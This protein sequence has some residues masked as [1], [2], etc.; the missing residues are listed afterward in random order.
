MLFIDA[1]L[2]FSADGKRLAY[3]VAKGDKWL[4]V[5]DGQ[6]SPEYDGIPEGSLVFSADGKRLAYM[7]GKGSKG[8]VVVDG[9][10]GPEYDGV[11]CGPVFR[12]DGV[13]E[14]L[15][16]DKDVLYRVTSQ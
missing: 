4:V 6:A 10:A 12:R 16:V 9:Q 3:G 7:A 1:P 14:Y 8:L 2:V 13:L 15:A 5:V 11:A